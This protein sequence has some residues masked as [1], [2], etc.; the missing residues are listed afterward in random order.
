MNLHAILAGGMYC[1]RHAPL[2]NSS[3]TTDLLGSE[4]GM[5]AGDADRL[6]L[7]VVRKG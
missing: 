1:P 5:S 3:I 4:P 6:S 7:P 2:A